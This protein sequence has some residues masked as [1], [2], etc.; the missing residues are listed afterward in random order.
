MKVVLQQGWWAV[1]SLCDLIWAKAVESICQKHTSVVVAANWGPS[2]MQLPSC[3]EKWPCVCD[4]CKS[5]FDLY[6]H[7]R[8]QLI[9]PLL[10]LC[11]YTNPRVRAL[12]LGTHSIGW[13]SKELEVMFF[14]WG[15]FISAIMHSKLS[16][17][18]KNSTFIQQK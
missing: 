14:I 10:L 6:P 17:V 4:N 13:V 15:I 3:V 11:P 5:M 12:D 1:E 18:I 2:N 16:A 7:C 9:P 8:H